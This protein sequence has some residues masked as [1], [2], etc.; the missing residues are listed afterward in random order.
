[1]T[2]YVYVTCLSYEDMLP[3]YD[4]SEQQLSILNE[5]MTEYYT[6]FSGMGGNTITLSPERIAEIRAGLPEG[7]EQL[8]EFIVLAAYSLVGNV[9]YFW[10]GTSKSIG[11]DDEWGKMRMVTNEGSPTNRYPAT[12]RA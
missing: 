11:W 10:G 4:F 12:L 7:L 6:L 8:R 2:K 9:K 5:M 3:E 1:M